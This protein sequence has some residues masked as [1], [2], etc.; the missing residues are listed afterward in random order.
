MGMAN[1]AL[2]F[3]KNWLSIKIW[4]SFSCSSCMS[5]MKSNRIVPVQETGIPIDVESNIEMNN[6]EE[7]KAFYNIVKNRLKSVNKWHSIAGGL[8]AKFQLVNKDGI[9]VERRLQKEDYFKIAIPGAKIVN[10]EEYDWVTVEELENVSTADRESFGFRV[11]PVQN[12]LDKED[13]AHFFSRES[14]SSFIVEREKNKITA[15]IFDRNIKPNNDAGPI[16]DKA[17]D[18]VVGAAGM[19]AF[20]RIQWKKL[21]DGLLVVK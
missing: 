17:R 15:S 16:R 7:A 3:L 18:L 21:V 9:E 6:E 11:R 10:G 4:Y 2:Q 13:V 19:L 1:A 20:A 14:T 5:E 8:S 12:P